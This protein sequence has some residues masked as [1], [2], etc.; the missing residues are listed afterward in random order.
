MWVG[1]N[2]KYGSAGTF[3]F[4]LFDVS[5]VDSYVPRKHQARAIMEPCGES[6]LAGFAAARP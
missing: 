3:F 2:G 1:L 4:Y 5:V 6:K